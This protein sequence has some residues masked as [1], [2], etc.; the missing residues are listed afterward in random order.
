MVDNCD[1]VGFLG[2]KQKKI[3]IKIEESL[4]EREINVEVHQNG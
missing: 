4:P 2:L 3:T 1:D